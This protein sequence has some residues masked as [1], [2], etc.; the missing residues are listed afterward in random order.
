M[1][2]AQGYATIT[3]PEKPI[4]ERDTFTCAHGNE[5]IFVR[6]GMVNQA[7]M[8]LKCMKR[9]CKACA[10][11]AHATGECSPFEKKLEELEREIRRTG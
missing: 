3:D 7:P 9:I 8:C 10:A 11:T 2:R 1:L 6:P 5:I 4:V